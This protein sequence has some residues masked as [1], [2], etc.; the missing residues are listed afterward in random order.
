MQRAGGA[1]G[2]EPGQREFG[3]DIGC[4]NLDRSS[5]PHAV[6]PMPRSGAVI[7]GAPAMGLRAAARG[8]GS[9]VG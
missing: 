1:A 2:A 4:E 6:E 3:P 7:C 8:L 5:D 9:W